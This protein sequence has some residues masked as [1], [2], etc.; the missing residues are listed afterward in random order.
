MSARVL[1]FEIS[2]GE[3]LVMINIVSSISGQLIQIFKVLPDIIESSRYVGDIRE[4]LEYPEDFLTEGG[5]VCVDFK[6]IEF[7]HI[8]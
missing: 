3:F 7:R 8:M 6:K 5:T 2:A 4:I 1:K